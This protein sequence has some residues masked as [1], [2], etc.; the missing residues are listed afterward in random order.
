M[1]WRTKTESSLEKMG[2][3]ISLHPKKIIFFILLLSFAFISQLPHITIDT[4]T[5]GFLHEQDPALVRYE[6]FKKQFGH[7]EMIMV[8]VRTKNIFTFDALNKLK[9]LHSELENT[10]PHL[11]DITS[12]I[13]ARNTRGEG[14]RLIVEDLFENWPEDEK[15]LEAIKKTA[16][17]SEMYENLLLSK[18]ATLT[19]KLLRCKRRSMPV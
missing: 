3:M 17:E 6:A 19:L 2:G 4:S 5:E 8:V 13:N 11:N 18:D 14:D 9:T 1:N 16:L 12:L 7:D 15:A 10:M